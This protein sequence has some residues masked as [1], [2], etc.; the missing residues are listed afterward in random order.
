M[1]ETNCTRKAGTKGPLAIPL[2]WLTDDVEDCLNGIDEEETWPTC[3]NVTTGTLRYVTN[4]TYC[5]DVFLCRNG[6]TQYIELHE[7]CDGI[8]TCGNENNVCDNARNPADIFSRAIVNEDQEKA[9]FYCLK[10]LEN[11][12]HLSDSAP[13]LMKSFI[14][15]SHT[16]LGI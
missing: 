3:G 6:A 4:N 7:L 9:I 1:T 11:V 14:F 16:I 15:P 8:E 2:T 12:Q 5:D 13:C 10:G